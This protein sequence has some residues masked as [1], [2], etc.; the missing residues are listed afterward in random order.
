MFRGKTEAEAMA[1]LQ[2]RVFDRGW[3][4][5]FTNIEQE[6]ND[7]HLPNDYTFNKYSGA[8]SSKVT[9]DTAYGYAT[10]PQM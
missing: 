9:K 4:T 10:S 7:L 8:M 6:Y 1:L 5:I 3:K 2:E